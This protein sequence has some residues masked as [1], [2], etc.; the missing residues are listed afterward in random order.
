MITRRLGELREVLDA[1]DIE[2]I[3]RHVGE[4]RGH[5]AKAPLRLLIHSASNET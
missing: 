4:D 2:R 1:I 5:S 3:V